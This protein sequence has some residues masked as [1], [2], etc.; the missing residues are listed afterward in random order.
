MEMNEGGNDSLKTFLALI[1]LQ[2]L[3]LIFLE[4]KIL[5]C[6]DPVTLLGRFGP[7]VILMHAC[8]LTLR[9]CIQPWAEVG[10]S[11]WNYVGLAAACI[12]LRAGFNVR[13]SLSGL[14]AHSD[15]LFLV[16]LAG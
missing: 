5:S 3:P 6:P 16:V 9:I 13:C 11:S 12:V 10:C 8:F 14:F 4:V 7:K 2:M 15:V 1:I